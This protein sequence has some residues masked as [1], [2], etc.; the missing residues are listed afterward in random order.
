[1]AVTA[2]QMAAGLRRREE[3]RLAAGRNRADALIGRLPE[4]RRILVDV[5]GARK[6]ALFGSLA[7]GEPREH[8]DVDLAVEGLRPAAY[9]PALADVTAALGCTVDLVRTEGAP[10]S[11]LERIAA[12]G[13]T[14]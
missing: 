5:H 8:S 14:L 9:F 12:E 7:S 4:A 3:L 1:M 6:V 10:D 13:R 2:K 11:L